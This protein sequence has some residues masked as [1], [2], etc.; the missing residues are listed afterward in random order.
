MKRFATRRASTA[1]LSLPLLFTAAFLAPLSRAEDPRNTEDPGFPPLMEGS[2][3]FFGYCYLVPGMLDVQIFH[4]E[5]GDIAFSAEAEAVP[6][7]PGS[8]VMPTTPFGATLLFNTGDGPP[9][10]QY[11]LAFL[12]LG[13][14]VPLSPDDFPLTFVGQYGG[15]DYSVTAA[16]V[17]GGPE[18][19]ITIRF[20]KKHEGHDGW[21]IIIFSTPRA[22]AKFR[23]FVTFT[24]IWEGVDNGFPMSG[25]GTKGDNTSGPFSANDGQ[26]MKDD[27]SRTYVDSNRNVSGPNTPERLAHIDIG[28][29]PAYKGNQP[30]MGTFTADAPNIFDPGPMVDS[31]EGAAP[32]LTVTKLTIEFKFTL[33]VICEGQIKTKVEWHY[34]EEIDI[35]CTQIPHMP[36]GKFGGPDPGVLPA[37]GDAGGKP[38]I[39]PTNVM[40]P[41]HAQAHQNYLQNNFTGAPS[42]S[43]GY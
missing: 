27:G 28:D 5:L 24:V 12:D 21:N 8:L 9:S 37:P 20:G 43:S 18:D 6:S 39:T 11:N 42:H 16:A 41:H 40:A 33:Y 17:A 4:P 35:P 36:S 3:P 22:G 31:I 13:L 25:I 7:M 19:D 32:G 34:V 26:P 10:P 15:V 23:Q 29:Y 14:T 38:R 2:V 30:G 1:L